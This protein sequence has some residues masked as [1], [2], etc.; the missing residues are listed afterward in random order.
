MNIPPPP[1]SV[2]ATALCTKHIDVSYHYIR[3][4]VNQNTVSVKYC[5]NE[6]MLADVMT[7]GLSKIQFQKL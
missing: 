4:Q 6:D 7:K 3:E 2:L 5:A 1:I